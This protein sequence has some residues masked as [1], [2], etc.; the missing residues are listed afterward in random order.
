MA[1]RIITRFQ[2]NRGSEVFFMLPPDAW[3]AIC[4]ALG[5]NGIKAE[6]TNTLFLEN[7]RESRTCLK[8]PKRY[9]CRFNGVIRG[10]V[11]GRPYSGRYDPEL[12]A[13]LLIDIVN[14]YPDLQVS[15]VL[16]MPPAR[17][18]T[19]LLFP[20]GDPPSPPAGH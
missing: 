14:R 11:E 10:Q 4:E 20:G 16:C 17:V 6:A 19:T 15:P 8:L 13:G 12:Y 7:L 18:L 5:I 9:A 1:V 2:K 3:T